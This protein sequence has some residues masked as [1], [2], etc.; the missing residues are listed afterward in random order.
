M[1]NK[2]E[3]FEEKLNAMKMCV[4]NKDKQ[5]VIL[6]AKVESMESKFE[7]I[8]ANFKNLE[9]ANDVK[10]RDKRIGGER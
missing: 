8:Q 2:I 1:D 9:K 6:E 10:F 7:D 3:I 4:I 5:I